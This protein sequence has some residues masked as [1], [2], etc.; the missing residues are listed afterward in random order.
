MATPLDLNGCNDNN[1]TDSGKPEENQSP[2]KEAIAVELAEA[3]AAS[4]IQQ[5]KANYVAAV[6]QRLVDLSLTV[7]NGQENKG[8]SEEEKE[9]DPIEYSDEDFIVL[10]DLIVVSDENDSENEPCR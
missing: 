10:E 8:S 9:E 1:T 5:V 2:V 7:G 3:I 4:V 6:G